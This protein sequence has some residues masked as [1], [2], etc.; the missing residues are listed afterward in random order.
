MV[1]PDGSSHTVRVAAR[2]FRRDQELF[3][4]RIHLDAEVDSM[5]VTLLPGQTNDFHVRGAGDLTVEQVQG[6]PVL[7]YVND[8]VQWS[9]TKL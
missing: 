6:P 8:S 7:P 1:I 3:V 2:T 4:D 9:V 5:L